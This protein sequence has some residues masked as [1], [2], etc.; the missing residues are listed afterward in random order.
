[1]N[2]EIISESYFSAEEIMAEY[3][4]LMNEN[5]LYPVLDIR[6]DKVFV[7]VKH[8]SALF[9]FADSADLEIII[10]SNNGNPRLILDEGV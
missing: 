5:D 7:E 3:A 8:I 6:Q 1:M 10:K 4:E 9:N 2:L